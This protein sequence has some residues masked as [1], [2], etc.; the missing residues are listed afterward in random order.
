LHDKLSAD[1]DSFFKEIYEP[2]ASDPD[3]SGEN[4]FKDTL[5]LN[6]RDKSVNLK[7]A[8]MLISCAYVI[9][10]QKALQ[11]NDRECAW[12]YMADARYWC[13]VTLSG[14]GL[15]Q[16]RAK[17]IT[18]TRKTQVKWPTMLKMCQT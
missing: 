6:D 1:K 4:C 9:D 13:A 18:A 8:A 15:D 3:T 14:K 2:M 10:V 12:S 7:Y 11:R 16:A 5:S 17:T